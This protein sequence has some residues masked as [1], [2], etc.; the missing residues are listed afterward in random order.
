MEKKLYRSSKNSVFG[1]VCGGIAEY[2]KV[3]PI[4]VRLLWVLAI[5]IDGIGLVAY[6]ICWIVIPKAPYTVVHSKTEFDEDYVYVDEHGEEEKEEDVS[7]NSKLIL[8]G[9]LIIIGLFIL[10][11][12]YFYWFDFKFFWPFGLIGLGLYIIYKSVEDKE[13]ED[14]E[15]EQQ[16]KDREED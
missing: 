7:D 4:M 6:I 5:L 8:G 15:E 12:R 2:F 1:G 10:F 9:G 13:D 16:E 11:Q 14:E 3:D